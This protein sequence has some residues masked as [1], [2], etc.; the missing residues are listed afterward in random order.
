MSYLHSKIGTERL[1]HP[2]NGYILEPEDEDIHPPDEWSKHKAL[3]NVNMDSN[4]IENLANPS[5]STD[6]VNKTFLESNYY[7]KSTADLNYLQTD[8]TKLYEC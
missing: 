6:A 5:A 7:D 1:Q 8:G 4:K 3:E 2:G